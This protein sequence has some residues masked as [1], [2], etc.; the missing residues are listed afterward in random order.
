MH[1]QHRRTIQMLGMPCSLLCKASNPNS[2]NSNP[3]APAPITTL[4]GHEIHPLQTGISIAGTT[5]T[6]G[7]PPLIIANTQ[8]SLGESSFVVGNNAVPYTPPPVAADSP[9]AQ[10][11]TV[12]GHA[13]NPV[14]NGGISITG[15]TLTPGAPAVVVSNTPVSF[16]QGA[17][18]VGASTVAYPPPPVANANANPPAP[19]RL[20]LP[21][22]PS[23]S[24]QMVL[25]CP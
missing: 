17:A 14:G 16:G 15:T 24:F 5:L 18:V 21:V 8:V 11:T 25:A 4:N 9:A 6:P 22:T 10:V 20:Q 19:K 7:A 1:R 12:A 13:I 2:P 23:T 3:Q